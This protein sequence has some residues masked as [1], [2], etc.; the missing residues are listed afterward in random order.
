MKTLTISLS[1]AALFLLPVRGANIVVSYTDLGRKPIPNA[2]VWLKPVQTNIFSGAVI[3]RTR[4]DGRTDASGRF[5]FTNVV[6]AVYDFWAQGDPPFIVRI[7]VT[8]AG[9]NEVL[10]TDLIGVPADEGAVLGFTRAQ[11]NS[12][13]LTR[14]NPAAVGTMTLNGTN[15][16]SLI[17]GGGM[18][19]QFANT[20]LPAG[21][22][23]T[24]AGNVW[25]GTNTPP[26]VDPE[27]FVARQS[28]VA[29]N[30]L[31]FSSFGDQRSIDAQHRWLIDWIGA[32]TVNWDARQL[33]GP[34]DHLSL[35]W[36]TRQ[37]SGHWMAEN[38]TASGTFAGDGSGLANIN[39]ATA[40]TSDSWFLATNQPPAV[41]TN[42]FV[43]RMGGVA[44]NLSVWRSGVTGNS[45]FDAQGMTLRDQNATTSLHWGD[46][47]LWDYVAMPS[48][49]WA[50]RQ[51]YDEAGN[52]VL[53][54]NLRT[55]NNAWLADSLT[56][57][58]TGS[59]SGL[60]N[61]DASQLTT[62]TVPG[63]RLTGVGLTN[64][65]SLTM[66]TNTGFIT[67]P[68]GGGQVLH[69]LR[70]GPAGQFEVQIGGDHRGGVNDIMFRMQRGDNT[71][72]M[73]ANNTL[74]EIPV[75]L[76]FS[77]GGANI[78]PSLFASGTNT[79]DLFTSGRAWG[80][81]N[82]I[83]P[84][85]LRVSG[86]LS[87]TN[88]IILPGTNVTAAPAGFTG[89]MGAQLWSDG[90]NLWVTLQNAEGTRTTNRVTLGAAWP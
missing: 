62:G 88:G 1:L 7:G 32:T 89:M 55:L 73:S 70:F 30:L 82:N 48:V 78:A 18:E 46:R 41:N 8:N 52:S 58:F 90:T 44:T 42:L 72:I 51:M 6:P 64:I 5:V 65:A 59:G 45:V 20:N 11:A 13:F 54:W 69:P 10:L 49:Q 33:L 50:W 36:G 84:A 35:N 79:L 71:P 12:R 17:G 22:V 19:Y 27:L 21:V 76:R 77:R 43:A 40:L 39:A 29:T 16:L 63:A 31:V 24:N 74:M 68:I 86:T 57:T 75:W 56:G 4:L 87:V 85:H 9:T 47:W 2:L 83:G 53:D 38:L 3:S 37:L 28:G 61:L 67:L 34:D 60:T 14:T 26:G 23:A 25:I 15:I 66:A 80:L 81:I